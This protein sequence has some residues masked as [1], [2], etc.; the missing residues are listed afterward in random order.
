MCGTEYLPAAVILSAFRTQGRAYLM[1]G[2]GLF[3]LSSF[4]FSEPDTNQPAPADCW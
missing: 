1:L 3:V 2:A 4:C